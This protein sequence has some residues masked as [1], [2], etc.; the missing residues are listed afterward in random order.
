M[1]TAAKHLLSALDDRRAAEVMRELLGRAGVTVG[2]DKPWDIQIHDERVYARVL[3]DG[4]LAV[5]EAYV[6]GWWDSVALDQ[7]LERI[8]RARVDLAL[9]DSWVLLAHA[10]RA[11]LFNRQAARAFEVGERHYDAGNDLYE[12]MLGRRMLYTCAYWKNADTLDDAQEAKLDLVCRKL[13][14]GPGLRVLDVGCGWGEALKFAAT[15]YGVSGVGVTISKEQAK[16][17]RDLCAGLPIEIRL[18]DYRELDESFD[19]IWS[20]G[21]FEHVGVKNYRSY[22]EVTRRCLADDGLNLLHTIGGNESTNHTDPWIGKYIFPN[23]MIPSA[24]QI[25]AAHEGLFVMEDWH[26]FGA[27]YDRTLMAWRANFESAWPGLREKYGERF[28]R[29]WRFYL[30]ASAASFRC[31][32]NQLWQFVLSPNGVAQGYNSLQ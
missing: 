8:M 18:Q 21:M 16:F 25:G 30:S 4:T 10:V 5:G 28:Y 11:R 14:L 9:R 27:D 26:N 29:M 3:R 7:M 6:E 24:M 22:F 13:G 32:R 15:H 2:G 1:N 17:A 20:I 19:R 23:S 12:A 31:R